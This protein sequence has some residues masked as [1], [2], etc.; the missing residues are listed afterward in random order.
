MKRVLFLLSLFS[1][2][3]C[4]GQTKEDLFYLIDKIPVD[5]AGN[6]DFCITDSVSK[7]S[8]MSLYEKA[9]EAITYYFKETPPPSVPLG[10]K[11]GNTIIY[12]GKFGRYYRTGKV[13]SSTPHTY[14]YHFT[15]RIECIG[16]KYKIEINDIE[17][18]DNENNTTL[19]DMLDKSFYNNTRLAS[20]SIKNRYDSIYFI[21]NYVNDKLRSISNFMK[22]AEKKSGK[23]N[24]KKIVPAEQH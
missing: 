16:N 22:A 3:T 20:N 18:S 1:A 24:K 10:D 12:R 7:T 8:H 5:K 6:I 23:Y 21:Y 9:V 19:K 2:I 13:F 11:K 14:I 17:E 4:L 15:L